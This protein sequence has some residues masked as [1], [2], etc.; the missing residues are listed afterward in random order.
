MSSSECFL[1]DSSLNSALKA[2]RAVQ[3]LGRLAVVWD[4]ALS[5]APEG[6]AVML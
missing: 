5:V 2:V 3:K 1:L 4:E 6:T